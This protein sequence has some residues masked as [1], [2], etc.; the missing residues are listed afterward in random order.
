M[1]RFSM[2][3]LVLA[4]SNVS[5]AMILGFGVEADFY[6]PEVDGTFDY[7]STSTRFNG[8]R[9]STYQIG[10]YLE[11]PVPLVPNLRIDY[12]PETK[13]SGVGNNVSFTQLDVTPYYEILD[14]IVDIDV[15]VSLKVLEG[16]I[17]GTANEN[18]SEVIPM[19]YM[20]AAVSIPGTPIAL[21]G[22]VKYIGY[23]GDSFS[24]SR[25]KATWNI[26]AGLQ[27]QAGYRYE[28]LKVS[29]RLNTT[30]N[31]TFEGPFIGLGY[32]F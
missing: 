21:S 8:D 19:G 22:S 26:A 18:F 14:T 11:H 25:I 5:A 24:D 29:N 4:A 32:S 30:A 10:A 27:F 16:K 3:V 20:G 23:D 2:A 17:T 7:K 6:S 1:M 12:T 13:F 31:I 28:S 9:E 15:G